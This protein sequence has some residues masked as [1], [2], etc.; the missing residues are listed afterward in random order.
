MKFISWSV[1][2]QHLDF[3]RSVK[4]DEL[5]FQVEIFWLKPRIGMI[6]LLD[7]ANTLLP[8]VVITI[9][10]IVSSESIVRK[11]I[12]TEILLLRWNPVTIVAS[13]LINYNQSRDNEIIICVRIFEASIDWNGCLV[14]QRIKRKQLEDATNSAFLWRVKGEDRRWVYK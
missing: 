12:I 10:I 13:W 3:R 5:N 8:R 6:F 2:H 1:L 14:S 11:K 4:A 7:M 9:C